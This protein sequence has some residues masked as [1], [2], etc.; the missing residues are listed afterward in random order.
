MAAKKETPRNKFR[1]RGFRFTEPR[2]AIWETLQHTTKHLSA[3]EIYLQVHRKYPKIGLTTVYRNLD[4]MERMGLLTKLHFGDG[5]HRYELL[6]NPRKSDHHHHL[7][8][9]YC[10][11][12]IDYDDFV[13]EELNLLSRV[14]RALSE[15]HGFSI[16]GHAVQFY[17]ICRSCKNNNT[18]GVL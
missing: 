8:C 3:E 16:T 11:R 12:V 14:E 9:T 10:K 18:T 13:D 5:R 1:E 6:H 15:K 7:V 4:I 17:G 2:R